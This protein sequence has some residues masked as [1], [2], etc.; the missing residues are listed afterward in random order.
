MPAP[1]A[2]AYTSKTIRLIHAAMVAGVL[3]F[4]IISHAV[5]RPT[6]KASQD[7]PA[8][9]L[10]VALVAALAICV[11]ALLFRRRIPR[12][13]NDVSPDL[14]WRTA[15]T[16]ALIAWAPAEGACLLAIIFYALTGSQAAVVVAAIAIVVLLVGLNPRYLERR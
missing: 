8:L 16:P 7:I 3:L 1:R 11:L 13:S 12:R 5:L 2:I 9:A 15:A 14:F 10:N 4:A 6:M